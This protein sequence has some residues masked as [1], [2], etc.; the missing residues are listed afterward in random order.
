MRVLAAAV[1][2]LT[3]ALPAGAAE[4]FGGYSVLR[5]DGSNAGGGAL[6]LRFPFSGGVALGIEATYHS[7]ELGGVDVREMALLAG[8]ALRLGGSG[9]LSAFVQARGGVTRERQQVEVFGVIIGPDGVCDGNCPSKTQF[10][11]EAG[12]GLD[13]RLGARWSLRLVQADYRLTRAEGEDDRRLRFAAGLVY[14]RD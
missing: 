14:R 5:V 11:A 6:G 12:A 9:R 7:G 4:V 13:V 1:V 2:L 8:P 10:A 3:V